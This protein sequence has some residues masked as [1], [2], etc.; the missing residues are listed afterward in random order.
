MKSDKYT[1]DR[2]EGNLVVLLL[3]E[4]ESIEKVI[5]EEQLGSS[6]REGD[7]LEISF[8]EYGGVK[9]ADYLKDETE[10]AREKARNLLNKLKD[11]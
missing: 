5:P 1:I 3:R 8:D 9:R 10:T 11:K 6:Y 4:D 7:I 2:F